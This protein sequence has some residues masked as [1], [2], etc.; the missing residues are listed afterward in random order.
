MI[1]MNDLWTQKQTPLTILN[2][3]V[4]TVLNKVNLLNANHLQIMGA[5]F[6]ILLAFPLGVDCLL[7]LLLLWQS[8]RNEENPANTENERLD[9]FSYTK[10]NH[11]P[12]RIEP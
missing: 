2:G 9:I 8:C 12:M 4:A 10:K 1:T 3:G 11:F 6:S 7:Q 5:F